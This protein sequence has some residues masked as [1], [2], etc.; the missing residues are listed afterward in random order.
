MSLVLVAKLDLLALLPAKLVEQTAAKGDTTIADIEA[1]P[2]ARVCRDAVDG[3][4]S[5]RRF[6]RRDRTPGTGRKRKPE[7]CRTPF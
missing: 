3:K 6:R 7:L 5:P 1:L 4:S 2:V